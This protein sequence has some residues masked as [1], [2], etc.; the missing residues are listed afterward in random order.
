[1]GKLATD[2]NT[3]VVRS[4][5]LHIEAT[6]DLA[7]ML[8]TGPGEALWVD[9]WEPTVISGDGLSLGTVFTTNIG[10]ETLWIVV[11]FDRR[12]RYARYTRF[13]PGSRAGTVEVRVEAD[14]RGGAIAHVTYE[15]TALSMEGIEALVSFDESAYADMMRTW[16]QMIRDANID[17]ET[18]LFSPG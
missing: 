10:E 13:A 5:T 2:A 15:L 3:R 17:Y 6:P 4:G 7:F 9:D 1:M 14:D 11:D 16:E 18:G 8:F 12:S